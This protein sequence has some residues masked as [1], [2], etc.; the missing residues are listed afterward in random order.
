MFLI[1]FTN[2]FAAA[3]EDLAFKISSLDIGTSG[4]LPIGRFSDFSDYGI[5]GHTRISFSLIPSRWDFGLRLGGTWMHSINPYAD[6][7]GSF[8]ALLEVAYRVPL[9]DS[10]WFFAPRIAGGILVNIAS[11]DFNTLDSSNQASYVDQF[12]GLYTEVSYEP[13]TR[14]NFKSRVGFYIAPAYFIYPNSDYAGMEFQLNMG[15]RIRLGG[16]AQEISSPIL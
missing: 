12:Y 13:W 15:M 7:L 4:V 5:G 14:K 10:S 8:H 16:G 9:G 1:L 11:G 3:D 2:S 6:T